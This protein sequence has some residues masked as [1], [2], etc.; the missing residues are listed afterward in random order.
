MRWGLFF[1]TC[2][3]LYFFN[4]YL[5]WLSPIILIFGHSIFSSSSVIFH[6][7]FSSLL[8]WIT[9]IVSKLL[10]FCAC[11]LFHTTYEYVYQHTSQHRSLWNSTAD[12]HPL[13]ELLHLLLHLLLHFVSC[14]LSTFFFSSFF[15]SFPLTSARFPES[16]LSDHPHLRAL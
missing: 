4:I 15:L 12:F 9:H 14:L 13:W 7:L 2:S 16:V 5:H 1:P 10:L 8:P 11:L 3:I 6:N